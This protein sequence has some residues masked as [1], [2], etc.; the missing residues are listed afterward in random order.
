MEDP[1]VAFYLFDENGI[2]IHWYGI[3]IACSL[4]VG[5]FLGVREAKRRGF[6]SEMIL[7]FLLIAIP[8]CIICA[9]IY[10]IV[11]MW[12]EYAGNVLKIFAVWEGGLAIYGA[13][14]G[15]VLAALIFY[16]WRK[17][18]IG[19]ILDI[20]APSII[21]GQAIG[22]WGNFVNQE[23]F[24]PVVT[25]PAWQYFPYA[26][27]IDRPVIDGVLYPAGYYMATFFYESI[28]NLLAFLVLMLLR[29]KIKVRGGIFALY[30]VFYG[31]GRFWIEQLRTDSLRFGDVRISQWLSAALVL[32]GIAYLI[33]MARKKK[34][35]PAYEG[36][37]SLDWSEEQIKEYR[38]NSKKRKEEEKAA[39]AQLKAENK[40]KKEKN[41]FAKKGV[42]EKSVTAEIDAVDKTDVAEKK[43][44]AAAKKSAPEKSIAKKKD[45]VEEKTDV[46]EKKSTAV[47]KSATAKAGTSVK[48]GT[49]AKKSPAAKKNAAAKTDAA[50]KKST[51][52]KKSATAKAGTS[53]KKG[54]AAKKSPAAKKNATAKTD[55]AE[56][57]AS[58]EDNNK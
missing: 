28:W 19:E 48:K 4:I 17:V 37:Y 1:R 53:V 54:T 55:A 31:F 27:H 33:I 18:S 44:S 49:A 47:K 34:E 22:R 32:G 30:L 26:V 36:I 20:A 46:A 8:L 16:K 29:K 40:I 13:V 35:Y 57:N 10:Y 56:K 38:E 24:G 14:I 15:G 58:A 7:D 2:A 45:A 21:I 51:A 11:P 50:E 23:A 52:V 41:V 43:G 5:V 12:P 42:A 9:R 25:D 39:K 6:R 3:I